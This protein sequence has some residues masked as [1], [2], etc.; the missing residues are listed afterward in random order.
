MPK[1]YYDV[2]KFQ[3]IF[4]RDEQ[5]NL[6]ELEYQIDHDSKVVRM[7]D[8][9]SEEQVFTVGYEFGRQERER[10]TFMGLPL[11]ENDDQETLG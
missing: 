3:T 4:E 11:V 5:G 10:R 1:S 2:E 6:I 8:D 9:L 7:R